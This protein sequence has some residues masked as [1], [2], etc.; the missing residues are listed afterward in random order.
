MKNLFTCFWI[1]LLIHNL[2]FAQG[3]PTIQKDRPD[4]TECPFIVPVN[5][6][7]L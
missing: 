7:Q 1:I 6:V 4:Q 5:Y 3:L 2:S